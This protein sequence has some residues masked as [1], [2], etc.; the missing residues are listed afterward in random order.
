[1]SAVITIAPCH[2]H[3]ITLLLTLYAYAARDAAAA[4]PLLILADYAFDE[5]A[6]YFSMPL[7]PIPSSFSLH[8]ATM[9]RRLHYRPRQYYAS[10]IITLLRHAM[11]LPPFIDIDATDYAVIR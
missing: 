5:S 3:N 4:S 7:I 6:P 11:P 1:M 10:H 9:L 8:H 2:Y